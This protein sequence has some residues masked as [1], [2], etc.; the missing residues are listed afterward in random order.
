M[1]KR[2]P[3]SFPE[4]FPIFQL[5]N[6]SAVVA[7]TAA[8]VARGTSGH[9]ARDAAVISNVASLLW[10]Y[11]EI[12]DGANWARRLIGVAGGTYALVGLVSQASL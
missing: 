6:R 9:V 10:A 12:T 11:G 4:R 5:P 8:A 1:T 7:F 2:I 3:R